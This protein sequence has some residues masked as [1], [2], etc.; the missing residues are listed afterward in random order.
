[1]HLNCT[2]HWAQSTPSEASALNTQCTTNLEH[3]HALS[4]QCRLT[5]QA[6][7][8]SATDL[9]GIKVQVRASCVVLVPTGR[10]YSV[11]VCSGTLRTW[12]CS[13]HTQCTRIGTLNIRVKICICACQPAIGYNRVLVRSPQCV[14]L[15]QFSWSQSAVH[16]CTEFPHNACVLRAVSESETF[17][18]PFCS[19][20]IHPAP[21]C[22][23]AVCAG[24]L[25]EHPEH[26]SS[27]H[28]AI[29]SHT[30]TFS[31]LYCLSRISMIALSSWSFEEFCRH[32]F[33]CRWFLR[34]P[35]TSWASKE[36]ETRLHCSCSRTNFHLL[37][38]ILALVPHPNGDTTT[39]LVLQN[40]VFTCLYIHL[41]SCCT[42]GNRLSVFN[43]TH[44][45]APSRIFVSSTTP[46]KSSQKLPLNSIKI[47]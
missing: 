45:T 13:A 29:S 16:H 28:V 44:I 39:S 33:A 12:N 38:S 10:S 21:S 14:H 34:S 40:K 36:T 25:Q 17:P 11:H 9:L 20:W 32:K 24:V 1:M 22:P 27:F 37:I 18:M 5:W 15:S 8:L 7:A 31:E 30:T 6:L 46:L 42:R 19:W 47:R 35:V 3:S 41:L 2:V 43:K 26:W 4:T 23:T